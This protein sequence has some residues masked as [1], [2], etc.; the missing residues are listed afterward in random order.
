MKKA[1]FCL[2][3]PVFFSCLNISYEALYQIKTASS[4]PYKFE[5]VLSDGGT[6]SVSSASAASHTLLSLPIS[7]TEK[8]AAALDEKGFRALCPPPSEVMKT[9]NVYT[10]STS[11]GTQ[12]ETLQRS[13][14]VSDSEW[15][16]RRLSRNMGA[17]IYELK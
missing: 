8:E 12:T 5:A 16:F 6:A 17:Y 2:L 15:S 7:L 4:S 9:V 3:A 13:V 14:T 10:V 1:L 11:S